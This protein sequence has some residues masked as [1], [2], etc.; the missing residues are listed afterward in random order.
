MFERILRRLRRLIQNGQY[1]LTVHAE[2]EM[3]ADNLNVFDVAQC[4]LTGRIVERQRAR[5]MGG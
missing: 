4:V 3:E 2:E 5:A 1:V